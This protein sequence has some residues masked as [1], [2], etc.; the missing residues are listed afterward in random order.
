MKVSKRE[1]LRTGFNT[2]KQWAK[3]GQCCIKDSCLAWVSTV[4]VN[5]PFWNATPYRIPHKFTRAYAFN[6]NEQ[7]KQA[8]QNLI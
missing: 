8:T 4:V 5:L 3:E 7:G 1:H 2:D 6:R